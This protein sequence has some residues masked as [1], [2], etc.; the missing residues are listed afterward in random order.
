MMMKEYI[1]YVILIFIPIGGLMIYLLRKDGLPGRYIN[2]ILL[3]SLLI[4]LSFPISMERLGRPVSLMIYILVLAAMAWC[5]LKARVGSFALSM[6]PELPTAN[7]PSSVN[8]ALL[9]PSRLVS[10]SNDSLLSVVEPTAT[11]AAE[12]IIGNEKPEPVP[13]GQSE[14]SPLIPGETRAD[15]AGGLAA[16]AGDNEQLPVQVLESSP[17][18]VPDKITSDWDEAKVIAEPHEA[19]DEAGKEAGVDISE[20]QSLLA[21]TA[22]ENQPVE[23]DGEALIIAVPLP[24]ELQQSDGDT[25]EPLTP[26]STDTVSVQQN[27]T[28]SE[29][30]QMKEASA[31]LTAVSGDTIES[32]SSDPPDKEAADTNAD[33]D[34]LIS[35]ID[36]A[37]A[38]RSADLAEAARCFEEAWHLTSDYELKYLLTVELAEI[39]KESGWYKKAA[40]MLDSFIALPNHKSDIINEISR[41]FDYISLLAAELE[42]LG[43]SDLPVSRI[44]RWV[45]L[46]VDAETNHQEYR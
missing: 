33:E 22:R 44:P 11:E 21:T 8:T 19:A 18:I 7:Q 43:I 29:L 42:R 15:G 14:E 35:L 46:K 3:L 2:I 30:E 32:F 6:V 4:I 12:K 23:K 37:F 39:F 24:T 41:Q 40:S 28:D 20:R 16:P 25:G 9:E 1:L 36:Y 38:C 45:R 27:E 34:R 26:E 10:E 17:A 31:V 5:L 13:G